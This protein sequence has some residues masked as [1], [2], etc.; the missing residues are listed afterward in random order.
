MKILKK[1][2]AMA[3]VCLM[4]FS[5]AGCDGLLG[6]NGGGNGGSGNGGTKT[7][8]EHE[9]YTSSTVQFTADSNENDD[10]YDKTLYWRNDLNLDMGDPMLVYDNGYFY[11]YGTRGGTCFNTFRSENLTDWQQLTDC[12]VPEAGSWS[13]R[14]LWAPDI[15]KI[16]D[17]W[18]LYYTANYLGKEEGTNC[19]IG[20]AIADSPEGPFIQYS[21]INANGETV[22]L[23]RPAF[24]WENHTILDQ[25]VFQDDDGELYMYF[26]YDTKYTTEGDKDNMDMGFINNGTA[27]IY[28]VHLKDPVTWDFKSMKRLI[29]PGYKKLSDAKR[30]IEWETWSPSFIEPME[31]TEGPYM[32]KRGGKYYLT[33]CAN[34]FVDTEYAVG[35]AIADTP[36]G[37]Y[38]KP[39]SY[40]LENMICGVPGQTGTYINNRYLGFTTGTGHAS[41]CKVGD[42]YL[43]A[44]HAHMNRHEWGEL[45]DQYPGKTKWR[46]LGYDYIHFYE[47]GRPYTNGPTWS[48]QKLPDEVTG[49]KNLALTAKIS[50][51]GE[52]AKYLNDNFTN[53]AYNN[54]VMTVEERKE[55]TFK[56]GE[57]N[58]EIKFDKKVYVKAVNVFNTCYYSDR[59]DTIKQIDFGGGNG[60]VNIGF[61][62]RYVRDEDKFIYP[63]A[64]YNVALKNEIYTDRIVITI[65]CDHDFALGEIEI[66]GRA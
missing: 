29:S 41:V 39:D 53:R 19:Q 42:E 57:R 38:V 62:A 64:A 60:I 40:N 43:L 8:F 35:Y 45:E 59:T 7:D 18:Y 51:Q 22:G 21:G 24:M 15:Q 2:L 27:E 5:V 30:T 14:D 4:A 54:S 32:I 63:H 48:L 16:G 25:H 28:G 37:E 46:A 55:T 65:D 31:C 1:T 66:I 17:K 26:S 58:I 44:Y 56:A 33:Y 36:L 50:A 61:N 13:T 23:D 47:D 9:T 6:G 49:Y 10:S 34:S 3:G 20:V 11:A 52:N 12:F